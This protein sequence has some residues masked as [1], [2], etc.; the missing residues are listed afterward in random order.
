MR[1]HSACLPPAWTIPQACGRPCQGGGVM[2]Q[3]YGGKS[4]TDEGNAEVVGRGE[5]RRWL[6]LKCGISDSP[7]SLQASIANG[8]CDLMVA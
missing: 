6:V 4:I 3:A 1:P 8:R 5:T 2:N 7:S